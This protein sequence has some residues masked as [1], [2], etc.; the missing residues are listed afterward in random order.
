MIRWNGSQFVRTGEQVPSILEQYRISDFL[1]W[2]QQKRLE[3]NPHFQRGSVWSPAARTYLIDTILRSFPIPK[4]YLRTRI[5]VKSKK[6][7]REVVDGQQRL[8]AILDF[9]EDKFALTKRAE[10]F[11]GLQYSTLTQEMKQAF[12]EFPIAV[13]QLM[14]AKDSEVLEVFARLNSYT[15]PLN[16]PELR[17]ARYQGDFKWLVHRASQSRS[18]F[19]ERFG[20]LSVHN[21]VRMEDDSLTAEMFGVLIEGV[22]DGGQAKIDGLYKRNEDSCDPG[23]M[24][25]FDS[26]MNIIERDL[27]PALSETPLLKPPHLLMIFAAVACV[28]VGIPRGQLTEMEMDHPG[29]IGPDLGRVRENLLTLGSVIAREEPPIGTYAEFWLHSRRSTQ[30]IASRRVR[31]PFFTK[32]MSSEHAM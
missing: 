6:S 21:R 13:D 1:E 18:D 32:A 4:V 19:W 11:A 14:N 8:R 10:E 27:A 24:N 15:V 30:R 12:L 5:D 31:F 3:L 22:A 29:K 26:V 23:V 20:V 25:R 16:P 9:A 2:H 7:V 28:T 17:H